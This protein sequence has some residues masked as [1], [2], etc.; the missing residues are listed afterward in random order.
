MPSSGRTVSGGFLWEELVFNL[1]LM[2][3]FFLGDFA[4]HPSMYQREVLRASWTMLQEM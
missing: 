2:H 1:Y 4:D 3:I